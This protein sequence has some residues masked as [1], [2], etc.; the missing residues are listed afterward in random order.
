MKTAE[1]QRLG[2]K[3][4]IYPCTGFVPSMLAMRRSYSELK[5]TGTD[6]DQCEGNTIKDFFKQLGLEES[7]RFDA[8]VEGWVKQQDGT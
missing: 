3:A 2:F 8:K 5:E 6:L 1:C 7:W 4:A